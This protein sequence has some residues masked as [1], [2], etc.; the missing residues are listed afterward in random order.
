MA[1]ARELMIH[2]DWPLHSEWELRGGH[3][4]LTAPPVARRLSRP[5]EQATYTPGCTVQIP[6]AAGRSEPYRWQ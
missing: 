4:D 3:Y 6:V 1:M 5:D 2:A